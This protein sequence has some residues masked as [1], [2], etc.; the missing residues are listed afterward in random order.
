MEVLVVND[1][2]VMAW[3]RDGSSL[4]SEGQDGRQYRIKINQAHGNVDVFVDDYKV[5]PCADIWIAMACAH[6]SVT[7]SV[8]KQ[9]LA[10]ERGEDP[11]LHLCDKCEGRGE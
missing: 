2:V 1:G 7:A 5:Q 4:V 11:V 8:T 10:R 6:W 9:R 3:K